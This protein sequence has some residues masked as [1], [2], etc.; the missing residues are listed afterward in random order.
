MLPQPILIAVAW[1]L[2]M[3]CSAAVAA[4][5]AASRRAQRGWQVGGMVLASNGGYAGSSS[6]H[7][8]VPAVAYEGKHA[9][10]R[11]LQ[12]GWHAWPHDVWKLDIVAQ[13]RMDGF[14]A[15]DIPY[16]G[17]RNRGRSMDVGVVLTRSWESGS[18]E[19]TALTDALSRSDGR[20]LAVQ[21][22]H[23]LRFGRW[24]ITP[25]LG[26]RWWSHRLADYY[27]GIRASEVAKGAA[28][29]YVASSALV[30]EADLNLAIPLTRRWTL[31]GALR[32]R[33]LPNAI[34]DSP[35]VKHPSAST[36][37]IGAGH[38]L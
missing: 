18:L 16:D 31:W 20:E 3:G 27:Y 7:L 25:K 23:P 26:M 13:A 33:H 1:L 6:R 11:G 36:V 28:G 17:L 15:D 24:R 30:P 14:D 10:L 32:Y 2:C 5:E 37:L 12:L 22:G 29:P 34:T 19:L 38:A 21:Y 9:F 4:E 8:V 35:L